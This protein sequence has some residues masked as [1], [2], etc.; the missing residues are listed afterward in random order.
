M[1]SSLDCEQGD[2]Q[3]DCEILKVSSISRKQ[4]A[5]GTN[6]PAE[7]DLLPF[8]AREG[9]SAFLRSRHYSD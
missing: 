4:E 2:R 3:D 5:F 8:L 6:I 1:L 9:E 7:A